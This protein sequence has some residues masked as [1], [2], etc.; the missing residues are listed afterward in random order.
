LLVRA[1]RSLKLD[2]GWSG[3]KTYTFDDADLS[4]FI[5]RAR[6][7]GFKVYL[8]LA[9]AQSTLPVSAA[10]PACKTRSYN[11]DRSYFGSPS[12]NARDPN[13]ICMTPEYCWWNPNHPDH[14]KNLNTFWTTYRQVAVKFG[15]LAEQLGVEMY[16]LGTETES[17]SVAQCEWRH[18]WHAAAAECLSG[19]FQRERTEVNDRGQIDSTLTGAVSLNHLSASVPAE[20]STG[21]IIVQPNVPGLEWSAQSDSSWIAIVR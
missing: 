12:V 2:S 7:W 13:Q 21:T 20:P 10:D 15:A 11:V 16:S 9:F 8:T 5:R 4:N 19:F 17:L 6:E 14:A 18:R 1:T 3:P